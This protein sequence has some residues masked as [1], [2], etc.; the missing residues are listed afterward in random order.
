MSQITPG[1]H[2]LFEQTLNFLI[3]LIPKLL[4]LA[5]V[6]LGWGLNSHSQNKKRRLDRLTESFSALKEIRHVVEDIPSDLNKDELHKRL[7]EHPPFRKSLSFRLIRLFGLRTE[8]IPS[9]DKDI[10][11]LIDNQLRPLYIIET[12]KYDFKEDRLPEF[13]VICLKLRESVLN[14]EKRLTNEYEKLKK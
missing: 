9:L 2:D 5:G 1:G 12:G 14:I 11:E 4:P 3:D 13:A 6:W 7:E 8:L 10:A